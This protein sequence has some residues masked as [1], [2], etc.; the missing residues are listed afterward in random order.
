MATGLGFYALAGGAAG[1]GSGIAEEGR[2]SYEMMRDE[3]RAKRAAEE[4]DKGRRHQTS[5]R[6][7][8]ETFRAGESAADRAQRLKL[9]QLSDD[10]ADKRAD[11]SDARANDREDRADARAEA[12]RKFR[13]E[14]A[15]KERETR[16]RPDTLTAKERADLEIAAQKAAT[17]KDDITGE[18][19]FDEEIYNRIVNAIPGLRPAAAAAPA[20]TAGQPKGAGTAADPYTATTQAEIDWFKQNAKAG[21]RIVIEGKTYTKQ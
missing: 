8:G 13:R 6:V 12:D 9:N 3:L 11:R 18:T 19:S 16:K 2:Q 14:E 7:A 10:R 15:D 17:K 5:E 1:L 21:S 4:A 20:S